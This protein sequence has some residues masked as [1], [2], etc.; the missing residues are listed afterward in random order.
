MGEL[1]H[2]Q[3]LHVAVLSLIWPSSITNERLDLV[4]LI[5]ET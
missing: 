1:S 3:T 4:E 5:E 2:R